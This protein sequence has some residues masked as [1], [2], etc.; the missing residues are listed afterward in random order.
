MLAAADVVLLFRFLGSQGYDYWLQKQT[1]SS[2]RVPD[3]GQKFNAALLEKLKGF[4][5]ISFCQEKK[6]VEHLEPYQLRLL[7]K[8]ERATGRDPTAKEETKATEKPPSDKA[9]EE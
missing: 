2:F 7:S 4:V 8:M 1:H 9:S 3:H 5:E 6:V